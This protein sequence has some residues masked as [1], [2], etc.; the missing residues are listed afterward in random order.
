MR[1]SGRRGR[2]WTG[3]TV[4]SSDLLIWKDRS[5]SGCLDAVDLSIDIDICESLEGCK[6]LPEDVGVWLTMGR[7]RRRIRLICA[8]YQRGQSRMTLVRRE[9]PP[10]RGASRPA[11]TSGRRRA[12]TRTLQSCPHRASAAAP[13]EIQ[14]GSPLAGGFRRRAGA[15][16]VSSWPPIGSPPARGRSRRP[17]RAVVCRARPNGGSADATAVAPATPA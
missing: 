7:L 2:C 16:P 6:R 15:F 1:C 4:H 14:P 5:S 3:R 11:Q 8:D 17:P 12:D 10:S 9:L 13:R